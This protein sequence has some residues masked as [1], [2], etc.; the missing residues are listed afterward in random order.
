MFIQNKSHSISFP[1][2]GSQSYSTSTTKPFIKKKSS[3][4]QEKNAKPTPAKN[5]SREFYFCK[6]ENTCPERIKTCCSGR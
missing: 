2:H 6:L 1:E 3:T 5:H 4:Q